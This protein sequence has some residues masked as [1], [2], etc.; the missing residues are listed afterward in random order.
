[1]SDL[2]AWHGGGKR[3]LT[4]HELSL[5]FT[6]FV[7]LQFWN[8]FNARAFATGRSAFHFKDCGGFG[9]IALMVFVGQVFIVQ[10]GGRMFNV[11]SLSLA[12]WFAII[13]ST[14]FVLWI[15]EL[16]RLLCRKR[17]SL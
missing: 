8:M 16:V 3:E 6:V 10:F 13:A 7:M 4:N 15:G 17:R 5:F 2:L 12:D 9:M 1:M 14:S 11:T